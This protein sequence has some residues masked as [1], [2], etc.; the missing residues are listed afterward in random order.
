MQVLTTIAE[1]RAARAGA[2]GDVGLVP[3]MGAL[4]EGHLA[5]VRQARK[6]NDCVFVSIFVNPTQFGPN[7]DYAAY[8][9]DPD[10]DLALLRAEGVDYVFMPAAE[11]IYP[12][13]FA[14]SVDVGPIGEPMEG[15]HRPGH[16]LG[17]A[18]V[19][20]KL[21]NIVQPDRAYFGRKDAQQLVVVRHMVRDLDLD[22]EIVPVETVRELDGLAMSSRN[23]YLSPVERRSA[24]VLWSALSLAREMWTRGARDAEA[25]RRR[26]RE[27]IEE[28]EGARI[29]YVSVADP[30]TLEEVDRIHGSV[31]V[32]LAV[33]IGRTRLID[34]ITLGG[35][36]EQRADNR[37]QAGA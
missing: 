33:R 2:S 35:H 29:D 1:V 21:F 3:T 26:M 32:S 28:E 7:E 20:L 22:V 17:V 6:A 27:L 30:E 16:F 23:A 18:T 4:H 15:S 37:Q 8:P 9:R 34:N 5:L 10:R 13:G 19:V 25:F 24:L 12:A 11:E 31:L 36:G 14:T